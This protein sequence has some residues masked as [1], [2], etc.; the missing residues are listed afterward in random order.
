VAS[1]TSMA[2][3]MA[4]AGGLLQAGGNYEAGQAAAAQGNYQ[5]RANLQAAGQQMAAGERGAYFDTKQANLLASRALAVA[6][7][8]GG[9]GD[10]SVLR[11]IGDIKGEGAYRSALSIYQGEAAAQQM[12]TEGEMA[13]FEGRNRRLGANFAAAGSLLEGGA[14]AAR[15][16]TYG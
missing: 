1:L 6:S 10:P 16:G 5:R 3:T 12:E 15:F 14:R 13:R 9:G 4:L 2:P 8:S 7:A 11:V